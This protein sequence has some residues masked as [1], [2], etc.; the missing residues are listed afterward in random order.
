M[1][2][3]MCGKSL[4]DR[5]SIKQHYRNVHNTRYENTL[6][7]T[8]DCP[9]CGNSYETMQSVKIHHTKVHNESLSIAEIICN[10]CGESFR[11]QESQLTGDKHFCSKDCQG[12]WK[13]ENLTGDNHWNYDRVTTSCDWCNDEIKRAESEI[14]EEVFC[15]DS[16][17]S[18]YRLDADNSGENHP[19]WQGGGGSHYYGANWDEKRR[20]AIKRANG[21]CEHPDCKRVE[22]QNGRSLDVHH[23]IPFRLIDDKDEANNLSNLMV[24]CQEHHVKIEPRGDPYEDDNVEN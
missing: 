19:N 22:S 6:D 2:C 5:D 12:S 24:L 20:E 13:S 10:W 21:V 15:N 4:V 14:F 18:K 3:S 1:K 7:D 16:C 17:E 9:T 23:I 11:R 8:E